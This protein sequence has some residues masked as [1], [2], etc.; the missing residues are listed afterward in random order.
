MDQ[1]VRLPFGVV[2]GTC[3]ATYRSA[4]KTE[5]IAMLMESKTGDQSVKESSKVVRSMMLKPNT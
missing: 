5:V 3:Y 2:R 4:L 1:R